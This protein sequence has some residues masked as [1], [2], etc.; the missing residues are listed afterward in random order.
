MTAADR[1]SAIVLGLSV[2]ALAACATPFQQGRVALRDQRYADAASH[3]REALTTDDRVDARFGLGVALYHLGDFDGALRS[4]ESVAAERPRD[5]DGQLY[6]AL[7]HLQRGDDAKAREHLTALRSL[8]VH[9]RVAT[10]VGRAL[11]VLA[12]GG[13]PRPLRQFLAAS[14]EDELLWEH[15]ARDATRLRG[16]IDP[17][18]GMYGDRAGWYPYGALPYRGLGVP[19]P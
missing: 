6:L 7:T 5:P 2:L 11:E 17:G 19:A 18:W 9:P 15:E 12:I 8:V 13:L 4:L 14:L 16:Q 10:Q 3:F 1:A